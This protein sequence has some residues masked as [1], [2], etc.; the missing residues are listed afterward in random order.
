M[1]QW[2]H[3][4]V[5]TFNNCPYKYKLRYLDEVKTLP[6]DDPQD[7]LK[8]GT[9]MHHA[10]E[11]DP[12]TAIKEYFMS[13]PVINDLHVHESMKIEKL[14]PKVELPP[15]TFE[16]EINTKDFKGFIDYIDEYKNIYD[17][18]YSNSIDHYLESPQ[19]HLYKYFYE[20]QTFNKVNGLYYIFV[21]KTMIRQKKTETLYEFRKRLIEALDALEP[22]IV[23]VEYRPEKVIQYLLDV[24]H[25]SEAET[26]EK[27]PNRLCDWCEY[28]EYCQKGED[29]MLLPKNER[30]QPKSTNK[31]K[32]Y[33]YGAP[34]S[35][36]TYLTNQFP[37]LLLLST[38]GNYTQLPGGVPP[39]IDLKNE[40]KMEGRIKRT[41]KAWEVFKEAIGELEKKDND[42]KTVALDLVDDMYEACRLYM[43]D[44]LGIEHESDNSFKAWDVIRTEF[45]S[46]MK[47]FMNL[48]YENI[49]IISHEDSTKDFTKRTGDKITSIR[50]NVNDKI[51]N[52]LA[53]MVDLVV[54]VVVIDG[55]R[56]LTFKNDEVVFGGGRL[57]VAESEIANDYDQLMKLYEEARQNQ[58]MNSSNAAPMPE[59]IETEDDEAEFEED[60]IM[61]NA[62]LEVVAEI[63]AIEP[64]TPTRT[65]RRKSEPVQEESIVEQKPEEELVE[66]QHK[67][68]RRRKVRE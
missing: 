46:T 15:G 45:L 16:F 35:G 38:D 48:D 47:R 4:R 65:R 57:T 62:Q 23:K 33:L 1:T 10:I 44:K 29:H 50:P 34:F 68:R 61:D 60:D 52:K 56:K 2:S 58:M 53:G 14:A 6:N 51:A 8:I 54:R 31:K 49:V 17:F 63:S 66:V 41:T 59:A 40:I 27:H 25:A 28:K 36:K 24:K 13:Y 37:D 20:K 9:A 26:F 39:H 18:K 42:F 30:T 11:Q 64:A 43:Y 19:L 3:S 12:K 67:Q 22:K 5:E 55:K 7:P 32:I 21:P